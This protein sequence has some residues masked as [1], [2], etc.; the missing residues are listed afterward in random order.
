MHKVHF[1]HASTS[2]IDMVDAFLTSVMLTT[3]HSSVKQEQSTRPLQG[4]LY[5]HDIS[6]NIQLNG[7]KVEQVHNFIYT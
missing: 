4:Q 3:L 6:I 2:V 7:E 5:N 1:D